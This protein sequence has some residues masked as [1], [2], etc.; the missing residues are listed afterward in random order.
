MRG[1]EIALEIAERKRK[2]FKNYRE[3]AMKLKKAFEE[4]LGDKVK[5]VVFGSVVRGDYTPLSD[6]DILVISKKADKVRYG[7]VMERVE[8]K[9]GELIGVEVHLVTPEIFERWYKKFIDV[10]EE[11]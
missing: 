1:V 8:E 10:Y 2:L 11:F 3:L 6:L 9:V 4:I 5:L 7:E